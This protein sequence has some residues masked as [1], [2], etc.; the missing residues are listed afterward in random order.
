M[1]YFDNAATTKVAKEVLDIYNRVVNECWFNASSQYKYG[2]KANNLLSKAQ[3]L[4]LNTLNAKE[5]KVIFTSG[6]TESNNMAIYGIC[7]KYEKGKIITTK[8]EH[9]S[10]LNCFIDLESKGF[11]VVYLDILNDGTV[12]LKQLERELDNNTILVSIMW[13]NNIIGSINNVNEIIKIVKKYK[14]VKL[15]IDAVQGMGKLP[16]NFNIDEVDLLTISSHKIHGLKGTGMLLYHNNLSIETFLHG[17]NQQVAKSGTID[18]PGCVASSKALELAVKKVPV[19]IEHV[20]KIKDY[21]VNGLKDYDKVVIN[22]DENTSP[23]ILNLSYK[24]V[25]SETIMHYLEE[26]DICVSI[27]SACNSKQRKPER[28]VFELTKDND[29]ALTSIRLSFSEENTIAEAQKFIDVI[30]AYRK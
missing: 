27:S 5:S 10:V 18:L 9:P 20:K 1:I 14:K 19:K 3:A 30:K 6:A 23:Y 22:S 7:N 2:V 25:Y 8:I 28:T 16:V 12:D 21:I 24:G 13:V 17:S 26:N 29:L 15:H 11:E 4:V